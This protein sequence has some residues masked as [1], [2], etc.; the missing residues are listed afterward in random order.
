MGNIWITSDLHFGHDK[1]FIW[2]DRGYSSVEEM[3]KEQLRK[4]NEKV[5]PEDDVYICGD[6]MLGGDV[7]KSWITQLNGKIHI[8]LGN[9]DTN[10]RA[11]WYRELPQVVEIVYATMIKANGRHWFLSHY[12][13]MTANFGTLNGQPVNLA[14]HTH[15]PDKWENINTGTYNIAVDAHNG[16]PVNIE[17]IAKEIKE[18][19]NKKA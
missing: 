14:G 19:F 12:P 9:H 13:T 5:Q 10:S 2:E 11:E 17:D 1:P 8:V 15:S 6:L 16:Y 18:Y 4:F 7:G 3:N